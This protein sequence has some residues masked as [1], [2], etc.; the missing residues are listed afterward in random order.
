MQNDVE[1]DCNKCEIFINGNQKY[2]DGKCVDYT[3]IV[4]MVFPP[5]HK[6]DELFTVQYREG[7]IDNYEGTLVNKQEVVVKDKMIFDVGRT[8]K[9]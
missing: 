9:S 3:Q 1:K 5:P 8:D 6:P 7:P 2:C 4:D